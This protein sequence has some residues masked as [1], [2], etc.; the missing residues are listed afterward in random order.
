MARVETMFLLHCAHMQNEQEK[1][2]ALETA[3]EHILLIQQAI[4]T[5]IEQVQQSVEKLQGSSGGY[6]DSTRDKILAHFAIRED[7]LQQLSPSPYFVRCDVLSENG[8]TKP[9]YFSKFPLIEKSIFSWMSPAARLRFSDIGK[10]FYQLQDGTVRHGDLKRKDQ[11]MIVGGKIVFM[12]SESDAYGRTLVYQEKLSQKKAGFMLPEIVERMERAQDDVIRAPAQGSFL[13]AG[14]AGSGKTTLAFHRIAY[15]LQSPDT[16][17]KFS[18]KN[19]I[20]FVQD[21]GTKAYFSKLLPDLGIHD[22]FVTTFG[23]WA[24]ERLSIADTCFVRRPNGVDD[25]VDAYEHRK[26]LAL[27]SKTI[28]EKKSKDVF[29]TLEHIYGSVFL[30]EDIARFKQQVRDRELDR[31]DLSLLLRFEQEV[32]GPFERREEYLIQRKNFVVTRKTRSVPLVY[33][34]IVIDEAQNYLPEQVS[35]LRTCIS[36]DTQAILYVGDLG[37]QVLLGTMRHWSHAGEDFASGQKVQLE[38][39][40]RNTKAILSYILSLGFAVSVPEGLREGELV[41]D[42]ACLSVEEELE[43][44]QKEVEMKDVQTQIGI[45]S[46]SADYLGL[47]QEVFQERTNVHVLTIHESQGVEF[48]EVYLVGVPSDYFVETQSI[49]EAFAEERLRIKRDLIYVALTRAM[50]HV[51]IFGRK[52]LFEIF[53]SNIDINRFSL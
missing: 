29:K 5:E 31:F 52:R 33:S 41:I 25:A 20:V 26:S 21:E 12:T 49:S 18:S 22:V 3:K 17:S 24:M 23:E 53:A 19:V 14:P 42:E 2:N 30:D 6:D 15:L 32:N 10:T 9:L 37:Q 13:I 1:L 36:A 7:Q 47:F 28:V 46:P 39:V 16:A 8:E 43:R 50:E 34:L 48:D 27:R 44:I 38:K 35:L 11:F 45:L 40:Y 51:S 4:K